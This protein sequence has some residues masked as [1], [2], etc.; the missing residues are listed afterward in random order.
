MPKR[1]VDIRRLKN[2][3]VKELPSGWVLRE[4]LLTENDDIEISQFLSRVP[5]YLRLSRLGGENR[6]C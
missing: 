4:I 1:M 5:I 6:K 3:A 2:F